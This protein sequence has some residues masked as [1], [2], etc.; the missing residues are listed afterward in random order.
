MRRETKEFDKNFKRIIDIGSVKGLTLKDYTEKLLK[1]KREG[2]AWMDGFY[3]TQDAHF[4]TLPKKYPFGKDI[5]LSLIPTISYC[6]D[7]FH[8]YLTIDTNTLE[9]KAVEK[10]SEIKPGVHFFAKVINLE[11]H[12]R[13]SIDDRILEEIKKVEE[14]E[15]QKRNSR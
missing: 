6:K 4:I 1:M 10:I 14:I 3:V 13:D 11:Y 15:E 7:Q 12:N 2:S 5:A 8:N 9:F